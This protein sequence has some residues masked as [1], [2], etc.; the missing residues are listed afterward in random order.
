METTC[1]FTI[2]LALFRSNCAPSSSQTQEILKTIAHGKHHLQFLGE[3]IQRVRQTLAD[4]EQK[5][6]KVKSYVTCQESLLSPIRRVPPEILGQIF[7]RLRD[8]SEPICY[9]DDALESIGLWTL[10]R[11]CRFWRD[12]ALSYSELWSEFGIIR[13]PFCRPSERD[14]TT[15]LHQALQLTK[16]CISHSRTRPLHF[17]FHANEDFL[18]VGKLLAVES[19]RWSSAA[20]NNLRILQALEPEIHDRLHNLRVLDLDA[21]GKDWDSSAQPL[22]AFSRAPSLERLSLNG[23]ERP[24]GQIILPWLQITHFSSFELRRFLPILRFMPSLVEFKSIED[25]CQQDEI[26]ERILLPNLERLEVTSNSPTTSQIF[27]A[28]KTPKLSSLHLISKRGFS[29]IYAAAVVQMIRWSGC[30]IEILSITDYAPDSILRILGEVRDLKQLTITNL[31]YPS[32][33]LAGMSGLLPNLQSLALQKCEA[34][35]NLGTDLT[36]MMHERRQARENGNGR[37]SLAKICVGLSS[38]PRQRF[39]HSWKNGAD[40]LRKMGVEIELR[41]P[42]DC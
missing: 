37:H 40:S 3:E 34:D 2:D 39:H 22:Q 36:Q 35:I 42:F 9:G 11:V 16:D 13:Q 18:A 32:E 19:A 23:F 24:Q 6:E 29:R 20:F 17:V 30:D 38:T 5:Q 7:L 10:L 25:H 21:L 27:D 15:M 31:L 4:L 26:Q 8:L 41:G 28:L 1:N 33:L 12:V 14:A